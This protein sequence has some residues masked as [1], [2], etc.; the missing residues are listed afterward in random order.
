MTAAPSVTQVTNRYWPL[1]DLRLASP[2]LALRPMT[3]ADLTELA[4]LL[5]DDVEQDP[6]A[7]TFAIGEQRTR[8]GL[9]SHQSYWK[10][11][12]T[13]RPEHWA[14]SFV[15]SAAGQFIGVQELEGSDFPV[16]R[17]VDTSSFLITAARGRGYGKQM[18]RAVLALAFGPMQAQAAIT[19]AWHD[20]HASLGVSRALGYLPNGEMLHAHPGRVDILLHLRLR[21]ADWLASGFGDDIQVSGFE[22][23]R[24]LFGLADDGPAAAQM[25]GDQTAGEMAGDGAAASS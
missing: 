20:N 8:R 13:W 19:S 16:L 11:L 24:P 10:A 14:L 25:V 18:R 22:P 5:P 15:V 1:F 3:E 7:A 21:R 17:T 4:D 2:D 9:V 23:C 12:G 6:L